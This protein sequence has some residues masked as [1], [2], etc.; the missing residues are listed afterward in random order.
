MEK[1]NLVI[2]GTLVTGERPERTEPLS[3]PEKVAEHLEIKYGIRED[4]RRT[5]QLEQLPAEPIP[6]ASQPVDLD[7][8]AAIRQS[9]FV[10]ELKERLAAGEI[11]QRDEGRIRTTRRRQILKQVAAVRPAGEHTKEPGHVAIDSL[12]SL[13]PENRV[14]R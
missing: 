3:K 9:G 11:P 10:S 8:Q 13:L 6:E 5:T 2:R 4:P 12:A 7:Q 1:D 14:R